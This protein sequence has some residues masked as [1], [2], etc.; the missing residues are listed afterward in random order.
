MLHSGKTVIQHI[1]DTHFEGATQATELA[2][3]WRSLEGKIDASIY[4]KVA[5][6]QEEQAEHSKEWRDMINT[7]FYRKSGI[8]DEQGR[9]IY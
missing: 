6:L 2:N 5:A 1:Y 9:T 4:D 7:Y 8:D 3:Q